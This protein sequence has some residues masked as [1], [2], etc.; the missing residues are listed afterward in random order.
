MEIPIDYTTLGIVIVIA[1]CVIIGIRQLPMVRENSVKLQKTR[2]KERDERI[3]ELLAQVKTYKNQYWNLQNKIDREPEVD[4]SGDLSS[5][6]GI[7]NILPAILPALGDYLPKW[8]QPFMKNPQIAGMMVDFFAKNPQMA[9]SML[10]K[11]MP[12]GKGSNEPRDE[13]N[14]NQPLE[15]PAGSEVF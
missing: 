5:A 11:F 9:M 3:E 13:S 12:K 14:D 10:G 8:A 1:I 15:L 4:M 2:I 7:K 6:E